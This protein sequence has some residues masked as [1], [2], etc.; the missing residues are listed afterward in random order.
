MVHLHDKHIFVLFP[1]AGPL[2]TVGYGA[3]FETVGFDGTHRWGD[4]EYCFF[5]SFPTEIGLT[6]ALIDH[7][8]SICC[9]EFF[10]VFAESEFY[11]VFLETQFDW[12]YFGV[13]LE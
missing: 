9:V 6:V 4:F 10:G 1:I 13:D 11:C 12:K 7:S 5:W 3:V 2:G 8:D